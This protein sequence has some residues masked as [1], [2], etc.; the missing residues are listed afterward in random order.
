MCTIYWVFFCQIIR[1]LSPH[2]V[3][4]CLCWKF[5]KQVQYESTTGL[6]IH[7]WIKHSL[8]RWYCRPSVF[9]HHSRL[10]TVFQVLFIG[11][12]LA[13]V[14][15]S[16]SRAG[17]THRSKWCRYTCDGGCATNENH[18][19]WSQI[20][21]K[22]QLHYPLLKLSATMPLNVPYAP[23]RVLLDRCAFVFI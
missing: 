17:P 2:F 21:M 1:M 8:C 11:L 22:L 6:K 20:L 13:W 3:T 4:I 19:S 5:V 18:P 12:K 10:P 23:A 9:I 15:R 7:I 14:S 16:L